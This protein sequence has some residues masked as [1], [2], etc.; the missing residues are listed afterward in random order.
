MW[1]Q[2]PPALPEV[3]DISPGCLP[4]FFGFA[5]DAA[6]QSGGGSSFAGCCEQ[7]HVHDE[8]F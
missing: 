7:H 3:V 1:S 6:L 5:G 2:R 4:I 8:G